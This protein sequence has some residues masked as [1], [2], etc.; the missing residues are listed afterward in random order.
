[1]IIV[2]QTFCLPF[3]WCTLGLTAIP[4][5]LGPYDS[6]LDFLDVIEVLWKWKFRRLV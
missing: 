2:D 1:M 6:T 5:G 3:L 4:P